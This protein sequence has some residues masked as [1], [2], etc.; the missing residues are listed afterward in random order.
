MKQDMEEK[1]AEENIPE[2]R[3]PEE[4][5]PEEEIPE[6]N[7]TEGKTS[8][9]AILEEQI[10]EEQ[11]LIVGGFLFDSY[12]D[13]LEALREQKNVNALKDKMDL[14]HPEEVAALYIRLVE[15][16]VFK[17]LVGLQFLSEFREYLVEDL[18]MNEADIPYIYVLP[19]TGFPRAKQEQLEFLQNENQKM[20]VE[21]RKYL[22]AVFVL[23][24]VIIAMFVITVLNPNVG[25]INTENKILN[26]YAGWEEDLSRREAQIREREA[27]LGISPGGAGRT[28]TDAGTPTDTEEDTE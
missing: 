5:I 12:K 9:E 18:H 14:N 19:S 11:A 13:A 26:R 8:K 24:G 17:T 3:I 28:A 25:Y 4:N 23:I 7:L 27:E 15:R 1:M 21:K 6:E 10:P 16:K 22:I 2:E 20:E